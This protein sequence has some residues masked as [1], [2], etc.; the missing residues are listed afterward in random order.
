MM[1]SIDQVL[2]EQYVIRFLIMFLVV[3]K[4]EAMH[5]PHLK[6]TKLMQRLTVKLKLQKMQVSRGHILSLD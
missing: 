4:S 3:R 2:G 6:K 1:R 5:Y